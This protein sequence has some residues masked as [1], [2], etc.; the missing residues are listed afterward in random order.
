MLPLPPA[1]ADRLREMLPSHCIIG[2]PLD[3]TGDADADRYRKILTAAE[4][5]YDVVMAIFGDP[6]PGASAVMR[7]GPCNPTA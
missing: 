7:P 5:H 2:N 6:I 3:V 4:G 1:L